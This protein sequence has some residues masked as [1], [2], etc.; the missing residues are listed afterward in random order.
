MGF[1]APNLLRTGRAVHPVARLVQPDPRDADRIVR[2]RPQH[3]FM[4]DGLRLRGFGEH[5]R[6]KRV[7]RMRRDVGD[8]QLAHRP[9]LD[10]CPDAARKMDQPVGLRI[11]CLQI[12]SGQMDDNARGFVHRFRIIDLGDFQNHSGLDVR[13]V[14]VGIQ[15][16]DQLRMGV[17]LFRDQFQNRL[18]FQGGLLRLGQPRPAQ[19]L[20]PRKVIGGYKIISQQRRIQREPRPRVGVEPAAFK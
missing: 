11:K 20:Q 9:L 17:R 15:F 16:L 1:R 10:F 19:R 3:Q 2:S 14:H 18:V 8:V 6:V 12:F 5:R 7:V 4:P 13:P